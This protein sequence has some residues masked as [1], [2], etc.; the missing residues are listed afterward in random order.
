[1]SWAIVYLGLKLKKFISSPGK[2]TVSVGG[3]VP[4]GCWHSY[5][6]QTQHHLL[7]FAA[8]KS[9]SFIP[10]FLSPSNASVI[11]RMVYKCQ[12]ACKRTLQTEGR[13]GEPWD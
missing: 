2:G 8:C 13:Y 11:F 5:Y 6:N 4:W 1:M 9:V 10:H 12:Q 3:C 7:P